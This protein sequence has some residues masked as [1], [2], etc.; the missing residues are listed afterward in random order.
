[1]KLTTKDM[2][3]GIE[4]EPQFTLLDYPGHI[5]HFLCFSAGYQP[6]LSKIIVDNK[7]DGKHVF[8]TT[9]PTTNSKKMIYNKVRYTNLHT[10]GTNYGAVYEDGFICFNCNPEPLYEDIE[11]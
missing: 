10:D 7:V 3:I 9:E 6:Q 8:I 11:E 2:L 5:I 1:M 4:W